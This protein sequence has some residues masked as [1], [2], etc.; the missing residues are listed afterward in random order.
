MDESDQAL[1]QSFTA[2]PGVHPQEAELE[3]KARLDFRRSSGVRH[4]KWF[5]LF[6]K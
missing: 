5:N 6:P 4:P 2:Y 3:A 1:E